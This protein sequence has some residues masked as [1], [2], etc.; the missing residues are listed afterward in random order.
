MPSMLSARAVEGLP[1]IEPGFDLGAAIVA[2]LGAGPEPTALADGDVLVVAHKA[3]SKAEGRTRRLRDVRA[4]AEATA[5]AADGGKDPR[6][7]QVVLDE[8]RS[9]IRA[10][11]GVL[12]SETRHGFICAN[13]GVDASNVPGEDTVVLLPL[14][15]DSSARGLRARLRELTGACAAVVITDSFGRAWRTGQCDVAIGVAGLRAL[16]DWRGG[17]DSQGRELHATV[18]AVAD[19]LAAAAD[20]ARRKDSQEPAVLVRGAARHVTQADGPGIAPLIRAREHD[21]FR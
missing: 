8:S 17:Q 20:L 21:L 4:G 15:P 1:E 7:V 10:T 5:L 12:I 2:R 9:L 16:E 3:V 11:R 14:D 13:A 19:Q 18:I 6:L